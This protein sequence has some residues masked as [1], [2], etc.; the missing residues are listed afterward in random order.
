M[1]T[2]NVGEM[3]SQAGKV[4]PVSDGDPG[5]KFTL[6]QSLVPGRMALSLT[7]QELRS[8]L[9]EFCRF[10]DSLSFWCGWKCRQQR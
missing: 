5:G 6:C 7:Q 1:Y 9:D 4:L 10:E 3:V 2:C 8:S